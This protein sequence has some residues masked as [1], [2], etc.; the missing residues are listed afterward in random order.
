[1]LTVHCNKM[2]PW[3]TTLIERLTFV[4]PVKNSRL[5]WNPKVHYHTHN[6][7]LDP[8]MCQLSPAP[9]LIPCFFKTHTERRG[10]KF[11]TPA[12]YSGGPGF[13]SRPGD[14]LSCLRFFV[15]SLIPSRI[16]P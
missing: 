7:S 1:M 4:Q 12:S 3:K 5:S 6:G 2:P 15:V 13:K 11:N 16:L 14:R 10:G 9:A 8:T